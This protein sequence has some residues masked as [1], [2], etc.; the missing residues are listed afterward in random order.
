MKDKEKIEEKQRW[1]DQATAAYCEAH[2][3]NEY[4]DLCQKLIGKMARKR[5]VPFMSG[6]LET[7]AASIVYA[8]GQINFLF[9]KSSEPYATADDICS[10]FGVNKNTVSG[11]AREIREMFK[12]RNW[13]KEFGTEEMK[14]RDPFRDM[15]MVNGLIVPKSA[16]P[17]D[18]LK[19]LDD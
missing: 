5:D 15:V 4:R 7:W 13:D 8:I 10:Y 17:S 12:M 3:N 16:L 9:D 11:K 6:K 18:I 14:N 1:L 2:L 19:M